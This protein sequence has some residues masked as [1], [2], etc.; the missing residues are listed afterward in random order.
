VAGIT[1]L[2]N[3]AENK[4]KPKM[5]LSKLAQ[6]HGLTAEDVRREFGNVEVVCEGEERATKTPREPTR[7]KNI[8]L[9]HAKL[10][11]YAA[12]LE[13]PNDYLTGE[14]VDLMSALAK[15]KDV[16]TML[17]RTLKG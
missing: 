8:K 5:F 11:L 17:R 9:L 16:Q 3:M 2:R 12:L 14:E 6:E 7:I 13:C 1:E 4:T 10:R 15:D